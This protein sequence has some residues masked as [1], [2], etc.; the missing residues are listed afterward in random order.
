ME[1][2]PSTSSFNERA[3][4][5]TMNTFQGLYSIRDMEEGDKNFILATFLRGLYYGDSWFSLIDKSVFMAN[6]KKVIETLLLPGRAVVKVAC[7]KE[8][9]DVIIGYSILGLDYQSITWVFVKKAWRQKGIGKSLVPRH[10]ASVAHLTKLGKDL[11]PKLA[12]ATFNPFR[13]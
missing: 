6:Y 8:E 10:P 4:P 1:N 7:L 13:F 9:P 12:P 11:L 3:V 2:H 5:G